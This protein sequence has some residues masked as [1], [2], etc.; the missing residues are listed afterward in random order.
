[1]ESYNAGETQAQ[2]RM[3]VGTEISG[4][5]ALFS[6]IDELGLCIKWQVS[7]VGS[8]LPQVYCIL[9]QLKLRLQ[10]WFCGGP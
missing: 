1:M 7:T 3:R 5:S 4:Q 2:H 6:Q 9:H 8:N 10:W